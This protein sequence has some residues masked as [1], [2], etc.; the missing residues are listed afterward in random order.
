MGGTRDGVRGRAGG[1]EFGGGK[2]GGEGWELRAGVGGWEGGQWA[3][4]VITTTTYGKN[5]PKGKD[6]VMP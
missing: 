6:R 2:V 4:G 1:G 3:A 5:K